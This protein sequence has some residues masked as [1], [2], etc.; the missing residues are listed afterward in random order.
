MRRSLLISLLVSTG[1][2]AIALAA[3]LG[4]GWSPKLGLDL[5]GGSEVVYQPIHRYSS[6]DINTAIDVIRNRADAAGAAGAEVNSQGGRI[7]VQ[8]PGVSN[9][10]ALIKVIGQTAQ[11]QFR[12]VLCLAGPYQKPKS[13]PVPTKVPSGCSAAQYG[14]TAAN[15][16][17]NT[18]AR[19]PTSSCPRPRAQG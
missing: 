4:V 11:M 3:T 16:D 6:G 13:G 18:S 19:A 2:A 8:L 9:P 12:P 1:V 15:L 7:V 14:Q 5:A 10:Q 17:V